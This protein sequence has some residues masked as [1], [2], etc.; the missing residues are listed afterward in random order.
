[1]SSLS[2]D[3]LSIYGLNDIPVTINVD[4]KQYH[5]KTRPHTQI[6]DVSG[7]GLVMSQNHT[8]TWTTTGTLTIEPPE[9]LLT[10][11]KYRVD[12]HPD[13]GKFNLLS[14]I[15]FIRVPHGM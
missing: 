7:L 13:S 11:P 3:T 14:K 15:S 6:I 5:P 9:A 12:C 4:D 2:L 8:I 1:M 10:E